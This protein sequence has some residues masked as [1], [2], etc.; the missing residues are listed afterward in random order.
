MKTEAPSSTDSPDRY[1]RILDTAPDAMV[2]VGADSKI[3]FVNIQTETI[4]GYKRENLLGKELD[5]LIPERFPS[6]S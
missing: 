2:I 1:L 5:I 6:T 3:T 4:F